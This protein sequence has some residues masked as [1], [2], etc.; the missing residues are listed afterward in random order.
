MLLNQID[1]AGKVGNL[2]RYLAGGILA[3][4]SLV[5][6]LLGA[7]IP[8]AIAGK[9][10][11]GNPPSV[12]EIALIS[13]LILMFSLLSGWMAKR[14]LLDHRTDHGTRLPLWFIQVGGLIILSGTSI[15]AFQWKGTLFEK[16]RY[17]VTGAS[18]GLAMITIPWWIRRRNTKDVTVE[19]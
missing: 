18:L 4:F 8:F 7:V 13:A 5:F 2:P 15:G 6:G 14:L 10:Q 17:S 9:P 11:N 12:G 19:E 3:I 16:T 1:L